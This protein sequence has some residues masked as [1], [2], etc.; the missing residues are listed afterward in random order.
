MITDFCLIPIGTGEASV[1]E[2]IAKCQVVLEQSGLQYKVDRFMSVGYGTN[3]EGPWDEVSA[4]IHAC[5]QV[6]HA[7]GVSRVATDIRIGTRTDRIIEP[8]TGNDGKVK[9]VEDILERWKLTRGE[10]E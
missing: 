7:Q 8:G 3:L 5:H 2:Y 10:N 4:A 9:R 1:A 6:V